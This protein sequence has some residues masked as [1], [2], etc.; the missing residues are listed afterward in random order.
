MQ[1]EAE[2]EEQQPEQRRGKVSR[3]GLN[4]ELRRGELVAV[5][6]GDHQQ[7]VVLEVIQLEDGSEHQVAVVAP[8]FMEDEH[9]EMRTLQFCAQNIVPRHGMI[10]WCNLVCCNSIH[11]ENPL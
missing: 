3:L 6:D 11:I 10:I 9:G 7:Y 1:G 8:D 2:E 5:T 4:N